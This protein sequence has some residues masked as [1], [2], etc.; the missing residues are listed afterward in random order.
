MSIDIPFMI[1][2]GQALAYSTMDNPRVHSPNNEGCHFGPGD[3]SL[4]RKHE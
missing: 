4:G 2:K 1:F 3:H